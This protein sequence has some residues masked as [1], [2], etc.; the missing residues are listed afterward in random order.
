MN[1]MKLETQ[2]FKIPDTSTLMSMKFSSSHFSNR[3]K[4]K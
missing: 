2:E 3:R 1:T 4:E